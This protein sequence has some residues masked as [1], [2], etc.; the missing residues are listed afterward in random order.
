MK[1]KSA[2]QSAFFN[3]RVLLGLVVFFAGAFLA[4]F[5]TAN[6]QALTRERT[7]HL[8]EQ[9]ARFP[10]GISLAPAGGVQEAW[11]A[12]YNGPGNGIDLAFSI[13]VDNLGNVYVTGNSP[14]ATS[15]NDITTIKYN[16]AG[17]Q[18]WIQ[19]YNGPGNGDDGTNGTNAIAVDGSGNVYV[20]GWS[21]GLENTDFVALK[22]DADGVQQWAQRYNGPG[23]SYDAP[24]GIAL[25][26]LANVYVTGG[27]EGSGTGSDYTTIK[28]NTDGQQQWVQRYNGPGNGY[29]AAQSLAVDA[30]GNV[31]VTG[32]STA[33]N[34]LGDC[35]TI[36]YDTAGQQQWVQIY[37]GPADGTDYG[38][39]IAVD[40]SGNVHVTGSSTGSETNRDYLTV[41]YNSSGQEQWVSTFSSVG[42]F[43]D[44]A[45]S[46]GLDSSGNVY[47]TGVLAFSEGE[48]SDDWGT[49]KYS[50]S[51]AEQWVQIYN[52]PANGVDETFSIAVD[53][54][55]N[56][57]V[58]GY[59]YGLTSGSD[60]TSIKYNTDGVQQW[61]QKYNGPA[62]STDTGFDIALDTEGN[63]YVT[64]GSIGVGTT[65]DYVAI[66]YSQEP[67]PTP[68][69][70]ATPT[71]TPTPTPTVTPTPTPG[72]ITLSAHGYRVRGIH[73]V[74]LSWS[75]ATSSSVDVYRDGNLVVTVPNTGSYRD[76]IGAKGGNVRY[77]YKVCEAGTQTCSNEVTVRFGGPPLQQTTSL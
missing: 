31:Y 52:G 29:D 39:S 36:K 7:R 30:L 56:S 23:N 25:D 9:A 1:K 45:R 14:G 72:P 28:Y 19:R 60:L 41:K 40:G 4:L 59:G 38:N 62:N 42:N 17:Q 68:T 48:G 73:T 5:A 51:G 18:Q 10:A 64:G 46:V 26:G 43:S 6:P 67:T 71:A 61:V 32:Y 8:G 13:A 27:S 20:T 53:T 69:P 11:V 54:D 57:Y 16:S 35:V 63:I 65:V 37:N 44:E 49:I 66:K 47:I 70:T 74:D 3:L 12:R 50:S 34:G 76:S 58:V 2:S 21:L 75:G 22:Y 15:A 55:G 77:T 24:Y 33:T